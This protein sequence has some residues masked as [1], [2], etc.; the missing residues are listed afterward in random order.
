MMEPFERVVAQH[1]ATVLRVCRAVV[2]PVDADDA[3]SETF[4]AALRAYPD[5]PSDANVE[6]WL[7][8]IAHRKAIDVVRRAARHAVPVA[9]VPDRVLPPQGRDLDLWAAIAALPTKQ[10]QVVAYHHLGGL[11]YDDVAALVGGTAAAA[12]RAASDGVATLRRTYPTIDQE[13]S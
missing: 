5:L 12:R 2:G 6:A 7:V 1:G 4:L 13:E 10:R 11:P 8:T 9:D 3:W